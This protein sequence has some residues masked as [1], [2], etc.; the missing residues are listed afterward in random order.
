MFMHLNTFFYYDPLKINIYFYIFL[1]DLDV[2]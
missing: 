1:V 2:L